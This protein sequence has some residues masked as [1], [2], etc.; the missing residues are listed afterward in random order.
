VRHNA[1]QF[2]E[3]ARSCGT[4]PHLLHFENNRAAAQLNTSTTMFKHLIALKGAIQQAYTLQELKTAME[5]VAPELGLAYAEHQVFGGDAYHYA[6]IAFATPISAQACCEAL[7]WDRP[8]ALSGDVHQT[9]WQIQ[10]WVADL[11]DPYGPRI[12]TRAPQ[13]GSWVIIAQLTGRPRGELPAVSAGASPAYDLR[14]YAADIE[15]IEIRAWTD[16]AR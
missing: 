16:Y 5:A 2:L 15:S 13:L 7:G 1:A 14:V 4:M 6:T 10:L 3:L 11:A 8:Y 12:H 9:R